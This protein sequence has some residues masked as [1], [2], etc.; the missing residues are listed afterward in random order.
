M[1]MTV[2]NPQR[3]SDE[4][5]GVRALLRNATHPRHERLNRHALLAGLLQP[6]YPLPNYRLLL[7]AL[8]RLY[9]ALERR[10]AEF[11]DGPSA[12]FDYSARIKLPW[13]Q[14]DLRHFQIDHASLK[15]A[16]SRLS[17]PVIASVGDY[18]GTLY[19]VEGSTLGGQWIAKCLHQHMGLTPSAGARFY[20]GYGEASAMMW[21]DYI[22]FADSIAAD[23]EQINAAQLAANRTFELFENELDRTVMSGLIVG[24]GG[25]G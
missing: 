2:T 5:G 16:T 6:G 7:Q 23:D 13:L 8:Y 10:L 19:V 24:N 25:H 3:G 9:G 1:E 20:S 14:A 22:A 18:V 21:R 11:S 15:T 4:Q 12:G 17:V